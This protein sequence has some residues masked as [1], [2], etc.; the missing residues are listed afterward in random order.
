MAKIPRIEKGGRPSAVPGGSPSAGL[1][2]VAPIIG[3][4]GNLADVGYKIAAETEEGEAM[5]LR[6]VL[7]QKQAIVNEVEAGRRAGDYEEDLVSHMEGLKK[8]YWDTPDKAPEQLLEMGRQLADRGLEQTP[9]TQVGLDFAQRSNTRLMA[10]VREMHDWA[11]ARQTQKAKGDLTIIVNRA[12]A[13][14]EGLGS[15]QALAGYIASKESE[16][17]SVFQNVLGSEAQAEM[18]KMK[19]EMARSWVLAAGDRDPLG[20]LANLDDKDGPLVDHLNVSQ[21]DALRK[22]TKSSYEGVTKTRELNFVKERVTRNKAIVGSFMDGTLDAGTVYAS[23]TAL[24]E[25]RKA[26]K[27]QLSVDAAALQKLGIDPSGA[28]PEDLLSLIDDQQKFLTY[29]DRARRRQTAFD[30]EDDLATS[31]SL[32][33]GVNKALKSNK[34]KDLGEIVRQQTR[35]AVALGDKK[36][37]QGTAST[38]FKTMSLALDVA[39]GKAE[40]PWGW[41]TWLAW[42]HPHVAGNMELNNQFEGRFNALDKTAQQRVRLAYMGQFNAAMEAG[43]AVD[44]Q[45]ARAMALRALALE[46]GKP[47][48]GVK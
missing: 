10:A 32:M 16:L 14:A 15:P 13:G 25:Q 37:S 4:A 43:R 29:I 2:G 8:E 22:E 28:T 9:N 18:Q 21:R 5:R 44:G 24:E 46:T 48:P 39:A 40:D 41:N 30:G 35:V 36:I 12:T 38:M 45:S 17:S 31:E 6:T 27:A 1:G 19:T 20:V 3:A 47:I 33:I 34:S 26:V 7:E 42:R 11:R 23:Q